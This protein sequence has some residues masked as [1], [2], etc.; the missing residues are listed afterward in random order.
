MRTYIFTPLERK[1]IHAFLEGK[2]SIRDISIK[3]IRFRV[4]NF[5]ALK[6]DVELYRKFR[7]AMVTA[8]T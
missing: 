1:R 5:K 2:I 7:E 3:K 4:K 6:G 8:S